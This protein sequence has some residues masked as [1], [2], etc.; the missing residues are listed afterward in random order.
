MDDAAL[1]DA[2]MRVHSGLHREAPGSAAATLRALEMAAP[3]DEAPDG[4]LSIAEM[5]C[6]PGAAAAVLLQAR[7]QAHLVGVDLHAPFV[8]EAARRAAEIGAAH[9]F[10]G[11]VADMAAPGLTGPFDL[12][13]AEGSAYSIGVAEALRAWKPLLR[14]GGRVAFS[15]AVWLTDEPDPRA[16]KL[17]EEYPTMTDMAGLRGRVTDAGFSPL[18]AFA[19]GAAEWDEYYLPLAA[20]C[21]ALEA[22]LSATPEGRE[23]LA[24]TREEIAVRGAAG[25]DYGYV[26]I[27]AEA[28]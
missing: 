9:R 16:C 11:L 23:V 10:T 4:P 5:G 8:H 13:W 21:D 1:H 27:V 3:Q 25:R 2:F 24:L 20:R 17:F 26:F 15:D 6:G 19:L 14:R 7:A 12:I 22:E 18:G 28:A